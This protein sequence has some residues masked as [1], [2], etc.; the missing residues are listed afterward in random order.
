MSGSIQERA[1]GVWRLRVDGPPDP[2]SGARR[3]VTRT[4]R[5]K[6]KHEAKKALA[7]LVVGASLRRIPTHV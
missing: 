7:R 5:A 1:K 4:V 6:T 2:V 3:P